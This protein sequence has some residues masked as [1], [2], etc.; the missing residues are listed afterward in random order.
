MGPNSPFFDRSG[1][2]PVP[3]CETFFS[4]VFDKWTGRPPGS[5]ST[6]PE[7]PGDLFLTTACVRI[8]LA[9][10]RVPAITSQIGDTIGT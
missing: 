6:L 5:D 4:F 7:N 3:L 1:P 9:V 2:D 10:A 8:N